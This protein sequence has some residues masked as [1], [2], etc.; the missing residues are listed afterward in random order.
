MRVWRHENPQP[1]LVFFQHVPQ[2]VDGLRLQEN[3]GSNLKQDTIVR[4]HLT[5]EI[6]KNFKK[7]T[8]N[9]LLNT[10]LVLSNW[11]LV[12]LNLKNAE[13]I[14]VKSRLILKQE[15]MY[16]L[17]WLEEKPIGWVMVVNIKLPR[18]G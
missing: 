18:Q 10:A 14:F 9:K 5:K 3:S 7:K 12:E 16:K 11:K 13:F 8:L 4:R 17:D 1:V 6:K 2:V 15:L